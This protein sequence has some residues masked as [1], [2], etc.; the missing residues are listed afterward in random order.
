MKQVAGM[1]STVG[2][3]SH[4][5]IPGTCSHGT[6]VVSCR[7][8]VYSCILVLC[9]GRP[10]SSHGTILVESW[11]EVGRLFLHPYFPIEVRCPYHDPVRAEGDGVSIGGSSAGSG[12]A[13]A[14]SSVFGA[15]ASGPSLKRQRVEASPESCCDWEG[16]Y[17]Q[18]LEKHLGECLWQFVLCPDG[19]GAEIRRRDLA[20]H[21]KSCAKLFVNCG[22]CGAS[23]KPKNMAKHR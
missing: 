15:P 7:K 11:M 10:A 2:P 3:C 4:G 1:V 6:T 21:R 14:S 8:T 13:A 23:V 9:H 16:S 20:K 5:T 22:I 12:G 17:G 19:C 18:L